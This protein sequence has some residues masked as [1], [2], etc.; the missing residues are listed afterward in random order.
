MNAMVEP[1]PFVPAT[2]IVGGRRRSGCPRALSRRSMRPS[3]RSMVFGCRA[4]KR[5]ISA[6]E[7]LIRPC[8]IAPLFRRLRQRNRR[9]REEA[10]EAR[11]GGLEIVP[12][13]DRVDHA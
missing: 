7:V 1:L 10:G 3:D 4:R 2:W 9:L 13:H 11:D 12:V 8:A 6:S 5:A